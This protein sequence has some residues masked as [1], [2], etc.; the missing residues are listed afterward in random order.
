MSLLDKFAVQRGLAA[1]LAEN[2]RVAPIATPMDDVHSATSA[3][4]NG[5]RVILAGTTTQTVVLQ[6]YRL[7]SL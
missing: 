4:I 2:S 5:R 3:T 1:S 7:S 6:R